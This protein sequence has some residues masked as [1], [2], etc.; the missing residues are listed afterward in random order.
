MEHL[1]ALCA[2]LETDMNTLTGD[3]IVIVEGKVPVQVQ[4]ELEGM[5]AETQELVLALIRNMK[6]GQK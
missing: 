6:G 3:S 1:K 5:T 4:R 2:V